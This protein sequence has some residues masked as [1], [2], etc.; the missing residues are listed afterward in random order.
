MTDE[1]KNEEDKLILDHEY[2]GIKELNHPL[3]NWWLAI[4]GFSIIFGIGYFTHYH[5]MGGPS[6][7]EELAADKASLIK[8]QQNAPASSKKEFNDQLYAAVTTD[9]ASGKTIYMGKCLSCHGDKG[10]GG[11]GP[12]LT[13]NFMI[14]GKGDGANIYNIIAN[15][16][17]KG[18]PP[19]KAMLSNE[20][21]HAITKYV[22][23][24]IGKNIPGKKAQ[25]TRL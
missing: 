1:N 2:D 15:G 11:I 21:L 7:S 8:A 24:M 17:N 16:N 9:N 20:E 5:I 10:Q 14:N 3:P 23:D 22:V 6:S 19:W 13:D 4:F 18:M 25:G 12:N